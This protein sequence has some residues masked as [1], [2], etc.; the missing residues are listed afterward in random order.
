MATLAQIRTLVARK[1]KDSAFTDLSASAYD[2]EINR[3]I[4][5]YQNKEFW[6]NQDIETI[7][8]TANTQ[9]VPSLP[10]DL[11]NPT[12]VNG[13]TVI[14]GNSKYDLEKI[15]PNEF[16][17]MDEDQVGVPQY[18]TYLDGQYLLLPTP[19]SAYTLKLRHLKSYA[20]LSSDSDTN[21]FTDN[22]VDLIMLHALK[23]IYAEDKHDSDFAAMYARLEDT[24]LK[25]I[26]KRTRALEGTGNLILDN[27]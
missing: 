21:D 20:D 24:E 23:N 15:L 6:F 9:A 14:D 13:L 25:M 3:A 26:E 5:Y 2:G 22:V 17:E 11:V 18:W 27:L 8:L 12:L 16:M 7:T 1:L 19:D 4:R 10:S